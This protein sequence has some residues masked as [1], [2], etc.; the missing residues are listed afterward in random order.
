MRSATKRK[1]DSILADLEKL[2]RR[3]TEVQE[4]E[5]EFFSSLEEDSDKHDELE[6]LVEVLGNV[7]EALE[8]A[9][10]MLMEE[11]V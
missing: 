1:L 6:A 8:D 11:L 4:E 10:T 2:A 5:D 7:A 9:H 3:V